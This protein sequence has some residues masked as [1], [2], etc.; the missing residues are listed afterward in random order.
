MLRCLQ[1]L[2]TQLTNKESKSNL[3]LDWLT[4][5]K[6]KINT[7]MKNKISF[8]E[9]KCFLELRLAGIISDSKFEASEHAGAFEQNEKETEES[10]TRHITVA[11]SR[12]SIFCLTADNIEEVN[13]AAQIIDQMKKVWDERFIA[14]VDHENGGKITLDKNKWNYSTTT[15][16]YRKRKIKSGEYALADLNN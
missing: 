11:T 14:I 3:L 8:L 1:T 2:K 16:K 13:K 5:Y 4:K 7:T 6:L 10:I 12:F 15:G 9:I